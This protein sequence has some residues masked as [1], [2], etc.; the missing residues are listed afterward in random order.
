MET[1]H[2]EIFYYLFMVTQLSSSRARIW[3]QIGP[4]GYVLIHCLS[5]LFKNKYLDRSISNVKVQEIKPFI[6]NNNL[7]TLTVYFKPSALPSTLHKSSHLN[8][9]NNIE[10]SYH[11]PHHHLHVQVRKQDQRSSVTRRSQ[12]SIAVLSFNTRSVGFQNR[13]SL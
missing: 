8:W 10:G 11:H 3:T 1:E 7:Q 13:G 6:G 9:T 5:Y 12:A 4:K 2:R